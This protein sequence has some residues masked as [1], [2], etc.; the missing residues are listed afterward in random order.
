MVPVSINGGGVGR[1]V[2]MVDENSMLRVEGTV[3]RR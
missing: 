2:A 3:F 1:L